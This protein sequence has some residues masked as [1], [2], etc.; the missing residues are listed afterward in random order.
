MSQNFPVQLSL[1]SQANDLCNED[2]T[3]NARRIREIVY[4]GMSAEEVA[5]MLQVPAVTWRSWE[6][7]P[8]RPS[9]AALSLLKLAAAAPELV[10]SILGEGSGGARLMKMT[11][12]D[13]SKRKEGE[14]MTA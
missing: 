3:P 2:G 6:Y 1:I 8:R 9:G 5:E 7:G 10:R 4:S 11:A 13:A 12:N 14:L